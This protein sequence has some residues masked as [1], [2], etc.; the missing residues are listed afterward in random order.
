MAKL[1]QW[2]KEDYELSIVEARAA[3]KMAPYDATSRADLAE[4]MANA[5]QIEV[6][7]EW[8]QEAISRDPDGPEWYR[9]NLAWA[10]YLAGQYESSL[11]ELEALSK[12]RRLLLA[13]IY[14]RLGQREDARAAITEFLKVNPAYTLADAARI[15][16][17]A[18]LERAWLDDLRSAGLGEKNR[19]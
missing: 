18:T 7:I 3:I 19:H 11:R 5:G 13:V 15:P 1:A 9:A 2:C 6:A 14:A 16:L 17:I 10:Y 12:P 4:Y 8:L